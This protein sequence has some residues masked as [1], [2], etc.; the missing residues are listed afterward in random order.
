MTSDAEG[1]VVDAGAMVEALVGA[2]ARADA[3]RAA[4]ALHDA[5]AP[6][7]LPYEAANVLRRL[8]RAG[9]IPASS[10][11]RAFGDLCRAP[12][13]Y[14]PFAAVSGRVWEL[15]GTVGAYGAAYVALAEELR[16]PL[17]TVDAR[18]ASAPGLRCGV[19]VLPQDG[20]EPA[21]SSG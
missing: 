10:A 5:A 11:A 9:T 20:P 2:G 21:G 7:L 3:I 8:E 17:L 14:W 4:L 6:D 12:V 16:C 15:R 18:L 19:M 13:T 1:I